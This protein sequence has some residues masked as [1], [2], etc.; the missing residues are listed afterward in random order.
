MHSVAPRDHKRGY[1]STGSRIIWTELIISTYGCR[2]HR[3][4]CVHVRRFDTHRTRLSQ[5]RKQYFSDLRLTTSIH[6]A[7]QLE[8]S[9]P[10]SSN[11]RQNSIL[12]HRHDTSKSLPQPAPVPHL[13]T[14][15]GLGY[16][17]VRQL[18]SLPNAIVFA[19]SRDPS[20][21]KLTSLTDKGNVHLVKITKQPDSVNEALDA[22]EQIK[23]VAGKVDIVIANAGII[24]HETCIADL[25]ISE[26]QGFLDVNLLNN[27]AIF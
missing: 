8:T 24:G 5:S 21:S 4:S 7:S 16:E 1:G 15:Q 17:F 14:S 9:N 22:A 20:T 23:K 10:S 25:A 3:H 11:V 18:R 19:T 2:G 6:S 12:R 26:F 13:L 27:I